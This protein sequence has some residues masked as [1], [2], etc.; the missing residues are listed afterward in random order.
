MNI[1]NCFNLTKLENMTKKIINSKF[2]Y[3]LL[4][5]YFYFMIFTKEKIN[6]SFFLLK[7]AVAF[8]HIFKMLICKA[9]QS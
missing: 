8:H 6:L 1:S 2:F 7:S 4:S 9:I 3:L 5:L